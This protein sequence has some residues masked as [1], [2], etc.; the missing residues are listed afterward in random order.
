MS[1]MHYARGK[2]GGAS[3]DKWL[4]LQFVGLYCSYTTGNQ[5]HSFKKWLY[6]QE[7]NNLDRQLFVNAKVCEKSGSESKHGLLIKT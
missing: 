1:L 4:F 6:P 7:K 3:F 2:S 5:W